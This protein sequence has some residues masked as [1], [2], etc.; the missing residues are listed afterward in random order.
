MNPANS[1]LYYTEPASYWEG[2][3]PIGNGRL[4]AMIYGGPLHDE[5]DLNEDTLWSGLPENRFSPKVFENL[6]EVRRLIR[7]RKWTE[8]DALIT[9]KMMDHDSQSYQP[10]GKLLF[11]FQLG[12]PVSDYVRSLDLDTALAVT[13]FKTGGI[14]HRR[15]ILASFPARM[16]LMR[17]SA[18][19]PG[20]LTFNARFESPLHGSASGSGDSIWFDGECPVFN[21]R[22]VIVWQNKEGRPGIRY[23]MRLKTSVCGGTLSAGADGTLRVEG[24]DSAVLMLSIRSDYVDWKTLPGSRGPSPQEQCLADISASAGKDFPALLAEHRRDYQSLFHRSVLDFPAEGSDLLSTDRRIQICKE[25][26]V[27]SPNMAALLYHFGRYLLI[28]SSR[29]GTQAANLQGIWNPHLDPP[30]GCNYTTNINLEMNYWPA[31]NTN[32]AECAEPLFRLIREYAEQGAQA[33]GKLYHCSGWCT[34]H[35]GDIWRFSSTAATSARCGFWPLCGPWLCRHLYEHYLYSGDE[36]FLREHYPVLR[37]SA[38]FLLD[39][40]QEA[41]DG[42]LVTI[43]STSPENCFIDPETG[44]TAAAAAGSIMDMSLIRENF[45]FV[46]DSI[47]VLKL[48]DPIEKRLRDALPRLKKPQTGQFGQLLEFGEDFEEKE[49]DHRHVSH[50]YGVYPGAE[51][52]P[53]SNRDYYDAARISLERRGDQSTGWAMGWRTA[54]WARFLSGDHA[55]AVIRNLLQPATPGSNES[56]IYINLFDAHPPFQIDG[57]FGV[58]AAIAEMLLQSHLRTPDGTVRLQIL[59][60]LP[61]SWTRGEIKGL[62]ARGGITA[63]IRWENGIAEVVLTALKPVAFQLEYRGKCSLVRL[64]GGETVKMTLR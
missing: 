25:N 24:A 28:S 13:E 64:A 53:D 5:L 58:T 22:G 51:F 16:I 37:G 47:S 23:Q 15:E 14:R 30:W 19:K 29:P 63:D 17:F 55:C 41:P 43:P 36:E 56:G 46:L 12:G 52:T 9:G 6:P 39:W 54:L 45:Q 35:N 42:T 44:K 1:R 62:R 48:T 49:I 32:L 38:L 26:P 3:I 21:R 40:L 61:S 2:A 27:F 20:E 10:A 60:A 18:G 33:A 34:H 50:L 57:N 11:D 59:P 31:E 8:A 4:G 7:E